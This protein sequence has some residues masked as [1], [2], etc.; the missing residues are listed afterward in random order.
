MESKWNAKQKEAINARNAD[1]LVSAGAGSGKTAVLVQRIIEMICDKKAPVD[2]NRLLV[3][4]FT[5]KAAAEMKER[6]TNELL[7]RLRSEPGNKNL[8]RQFMLLSQSKISTIHSFCLD[9]IRNNFGQAGLEPDFKIIDENLNKLLWEKALQK[10]KENVLNDENLSHL[11]D[12]YGFSKNGEAIDSLVAAMH[13]VCVAQPFPDIWIKQAQENFLCDNITEMEFLKVIMENVVIILKGIRDELSDI[14]YFLS[15]EPLLS[16]YLPVFI[17]AKEEIDK[18]IAQKDDYNTLGTALSHFSFMRLPS[19]RDPQDPE[20]VEYIKKVKT[21]LSQKLKKL[22]TDYFSSD[23]DDIASQNKAF[24]DV[25]KLICELY[26]HFIKIYEIEKRGY[27]SIDYNDMERICLDILIERKDEGFIQSAAAKE[28]MESIDEIYIDEYQDSNMMQDHILFSVSK[29]S[30]GVHNVFMVGDV[31]QSIYRFRLAMPE[32]FISKYNEYSQDTGALRLKINLQENYRS[33]KE[34]I[35]Y[36]N[37]T[38]SV[39]MTKNAGEIDYTQDQMLRSAMEYPPV[40]DEAFIG[41]HVYDKKEETEEGIE[42]LE[43]AQK[44]ALI[45]KDI[46]N[47]LTGTKKIVDANGT[48]RDI[49]YRDIVILAR[50]VK[51]FASDVR[52]ILLSQGIPVY[53][54]GEEGYFDQLEVRLA[55]A[56]LNIVDNSYQDIDMA[57]IMRSYIGGFTLEE[58]ARIR[59][60]DKQ[61]YLYSNLESAAENDLK[62]K[63]LID[64]ITSV[65]R[66]KYSYRLHELIDRIFDRLYFLEYSRALPSGELRIANLRLLLSRAKEYE[67]GIGGSLFSFLNYVSDMSSKKISPEAAKTIAENENVVRIMSV[68]SSKGLQFP[69][70]I[71]ANTGKKFNRMDERGLLLTHRTLGAGPEI[72]EKDRKLRY[73]SVIKKAIAQKTMLENISEEMRVLYVALTRARERLYI[74]GGKAGVEGYISKLARRPAVNEYN[75]I[76]AG[77]FLDWILLSLKDQSLINPV[78]INQITREESDEYKVY[79]EIQEAEALDPMT[80][81]KIS[82]EYPY[83][84]NSKY[85][86]KITVT[87][88]KKFR[89][90]LLSGENADDQIDPEFL[91]DSHKPAFAE[92]KALLSPKERGTIYHYV[93]QLIDFKNT[94]SFEAVESQLNDFFNRGFLSKREYESIN[95]R[96]IYSFFDSQIGRRCRLA[97]KLY[98]ETPFNAVLDIQGDQDDEPV[99]QGVIDLFFETDDGVVLVDYKTDY[100]KIGEEDILTRRYKKQLEYYSY[101]LKKLTGR[102]VLEKYIYSFYLSK[103]IRT[104]D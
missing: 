1:I 7:T 79:E 9:V 73:D 102:P 40:G 89:Y 99:L 10:T 97:E 93:M 29:Q 14:E 81:D 83:L 75:V 27:N 90:D 62:C 21:E 5:K 77:S 78:R 42:E 12:Y 84:E 55:L 63:K 22:H 80:A 82:W 38:F 28:I 3:V 60:L 103:S 64:L 85:P 47:D 17:N 70:V 52:D 25:F 66:E 43:D 101:A 20:G 23:P 37:D 61:A 41:I 53:A 58:I 56:F 65:K 69:C 26:H 48:I 50:S 39:L 88:L 95:C 15:D 72:I 4:T 36:I 100:V 24:S 98:K 71:L 96:Y 104:D 87:E 16:V 32:L 68:H 11:F 45:I 2:I 19:V 92:D 51:G 33:R 44:E 35:D 94:G 30:F 76:Y 67:E 6:I 59:M 86:A 49:E 54:Q 18:V 91:F 57:A 34:I 13:K 31:K 46:I 8:T 74:T